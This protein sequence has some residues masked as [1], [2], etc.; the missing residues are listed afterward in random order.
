MSIGTSDST[1]PVKP[2]SVNRN[3]KPMANSIGVSKV[4][5][6]FHIVATQLNTFTPVGTAIS[7]LE[8][9]KNN[10]L[11]TGIP[12]VNMWCAQTVNDRIAMDAVAYTIEAYPNSG[13]LAKVG[14]ICEMMPNAGRIR[15][16]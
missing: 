1:R 3:R 6:P 9:M 16:Y 13:F 5:E 8:N 10:W 2:P 12:V 4:S 11:A 14:M 7:M 15:M